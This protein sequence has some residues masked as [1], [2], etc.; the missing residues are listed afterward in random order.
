MGIAWSRITFEWW[1]VCVCESLSRDQHFATLWA[2]AHQAP[3]SMGFS[4]QGDW[5]GLPCPPPGDLP[6]WGTEPGS[7]ALQAD[8]LPAEPPGNMCIEWVLGFIMSLFGGCVCVCVCVYFFVR[9]KTKPTSFMASDHPPC[10]PSWWFSFLPPPLLLPMTLFLSP[11][12]PGCFPACHDFSDWHWVSDSCSPKPSPQ[13]HPVLNSR[14]PA[15]L[16]PPLKHAECLL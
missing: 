15:A 5:S 11:A 12:S 1:L 9:P 10:C 2:V 14:P 6:N 7:P 4:R 3:L 8:S 16:W 13:T